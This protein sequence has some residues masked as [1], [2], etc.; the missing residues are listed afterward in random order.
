MKKEKSDKRSDINRGENISLMEPMI[1][2]EN[3]RHYQKL[4]DLTVDL[5]AKSAGFKRS[6]PT[7][8]QISL[9]NLVRAM[10][11]YYSNLIEGHNTHPIAIE[12]ALRGDY[13]KD[14]KKRNLQLEAKAHITVQEW[15]DSGSIKDSI[16][17]STTLCEI[18]KRFC[19]LL[20]D[21]LLW[22]EDPETKEKLKVIP[23]EI[24]HSDVQVGN[25][26]AISPNNIPRFLTRFENVYQPLGKAATILAMAASHHRLLWVHPFLDGNGRVA[27]LMSHAVTLNVLNN[28][29]IWSISR[30]LARNATAYKEH[31]ANCDLQRRN[32]LDGRG[33]LSEEMLAEFT[34]FF[35][36]TCLD[37]VNYMEKLMQPDQLRTRIL[38][39]AQE[40]SQ[41]GELPSQAI[42]ILEAILYRG[43]ISRG[44]MATILNVSDR[45]A[46]RLTA[47]LFEK[48]ILISDTPKAP[49]RLALPAT[50]AYRWLPGLF[51][52]S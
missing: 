7:A 47:P 31:L 38:L 16:F 42:Q 40:E 45:H 52:P 21:D 50:L 18:H 25:H 20:P 17:S 2:S 14:S 9:A 3:S 27:R 8:L 13:S 32:D 11:C 26:I 1:I 10:N 4:M 30:G 19:E 43:E 48:G 34:Q 5:A 29:A 51:P 23:G 37:Q 41:L 36:E 49:F 44:E 28:D 46:R 24:R 6:L 39:W 12:Q 15:I 22:V 35:L 33:N